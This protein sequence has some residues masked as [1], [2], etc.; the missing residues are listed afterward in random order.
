MSWDE[1]LWQRSF[2]NIQMLGNSIP[3]YDKEG[4]KTE[5]IKPVT[6][7]DLFERFKKE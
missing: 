4:N 1:I 5:G 7:K 6:G 3:V 2:M